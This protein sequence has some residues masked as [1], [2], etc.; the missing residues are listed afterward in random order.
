MYG[1]IYKT[2]NLITGKMYI[3]QHKSDTFDEGYKGSGKL[4]KQAIA[5]YGKDNFSCEIL[6]MIN[7]VPT[8]C[9]SAEQ[10]GESEYYYIKYYN[11]DTSDDYYNLCEGGI[12]RSVVGQIFINNGSNEKKIFPDN[13]ET[14]QKLGWEKGKLPQSET[15]IRRRV[16]KCQGQKRSKDACERIS[17]ALKGKPKSAEHVAKVQATKKNKHCV[18]PNKGRVAMLF[19]DHLVYVNK[20]DVESYIALGYILSGKKHTEEACE[21]QSI[22]KRGTIAVTDGNKTKFIK[23]SELPVYLDLGFTLGRHEPTRPNQKSEHRKWVNDGQHT[24]MI[25]QEEL[26]EYLNKGYILGRLKFK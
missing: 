15:T 16:S 21:R 5:K 2:T 14:Y 19:E 11:A 9:E 4:L 18:A 22:A 7:D 20:Q 1:Y 25:K 12:H 17:K 10:L 6:E 3:G 8:I 13:L 24:F 23:Q 26:E